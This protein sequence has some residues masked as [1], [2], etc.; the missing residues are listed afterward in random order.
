MKSNKRKIRA[1][2]ALILNSVTS[3]IQLELEDKN[4]LENPLKTIAYIKSTYSIASERA[5]TGLLEKINNC[6]LSD[7][8]SM[9]EYINKDREFK[10]D[11]HRGKLATYTDGSMVTSMLAGLPAECNSFRMQWGRDRAK[12]MDK[13]PNLD[14]L[15][16]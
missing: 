9:T 2:Q 7:S 6:K 5:R 4:L 8:K 12:D 14:S 3:S 13:D 11:L 1:L 10:F 15:V 16:D